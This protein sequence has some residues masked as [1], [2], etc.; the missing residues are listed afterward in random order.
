MRF[1]RWRIHRCGVARV[2][3]SACLEILPAA[4]TSSPVEGAHEQSLL[5]NE[6]GR[7]GLGV[8]TDANPEG[9]F[10]FVSDAPQ[11]DDVKFRSANLC[12]GR[13]GGAPLRRPC[14]RLCGRRLD[15]AGKVTRG[16]CSRR[17][18]VALQRA[19]PDMSSRQ[20]RS[21]TAR[22]RRRESRCAGFQ[23]RLPLIGERGVLISST[24][25]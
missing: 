18:T 16:L 7:Q 22:R 2:S 14:L 17:A 12:K 25:L 10:Q 8:R 4:A 5:F 24:S 6:A 3:L 9:L 19:I 23:A 20:G 21:G 1:R 13:L 11:I 15:H